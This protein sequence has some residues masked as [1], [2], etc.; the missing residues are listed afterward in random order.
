MNERIVL[1]LKKI[2]TSR[3]NDIIVEDKIEF[4][5]EINLINSKRIKSISVFITIL[6]FILI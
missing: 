3:S 2:F 6:D 5:E 1:N 4:T